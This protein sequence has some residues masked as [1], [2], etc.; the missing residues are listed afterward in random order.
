MG[1]VEV[2]E[3]ENRK[4]GL[5][6]DVEAQLQEQEEAGNDG[7]T[8]AGFHITNAQLPMIGTFFSA[9]ILL[10]AILVGGKSLKNYEYTISVAAVAM[11]FSLLG[12]LLTSCRKDNDD[13]T[14]QFNGIFLFLWCFIGA[15][16]LTFNGP[17]KITGNGYFASWSLAICSTM[18]VGVTGKKAK[19]FVTGIGAVL[20]LGASA[21]VVIAALI[22]E[23]RDDDIYRNQEIYALVVSCV[24]IVL[25]GVLACQGHG[26]ETVEPSKLKFLLLAIF[27]ILW[28][29]LASIVTF[30]GPFRDTGNGYFG[31]WVGAIMSVWAAMGALRGT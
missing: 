10:V 18:S 20:G 5:T 3:S 12:F 9:L 15:C 17:F 28:I 27:S 24:T 16:V 25:V 8:V 4:P 19:S 2:V 23:M 26:K 29:V 13:K 1:E 21:I 31:V 6:A 22:P 7:V 11:F 14:S 30:D